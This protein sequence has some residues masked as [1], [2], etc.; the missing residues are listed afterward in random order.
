MGEGLPQFSRKLRD[1]VPQAKASAWEI[2][3]NLMRSELT[4]AQE[5]DCMAR[6]K[7]LWKAKNSGASCATIRDRPG[8]PAGFAADTATKTGR[9]K[10]T[11]NRAASRGEKIAP[12]ANTRAGYSTPRPWR[13]S[14]HRATIRAHVGGGRP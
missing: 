4:P 8:M 1:A 12:G 11:V 7:A 5:A 6:R 10:S 13:R 14:R 9:D 2:D 3:E